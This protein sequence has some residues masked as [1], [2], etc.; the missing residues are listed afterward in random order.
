MLK[1]RRI[2]ALAWT[3]DY[4]IQDDR[5]EIVHMLEPETAANVVA[6]VNP[7]NRLHNECGLLELLIRHK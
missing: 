2:N 3:I 4:R 1:K 6:Q 7:Q 5:G